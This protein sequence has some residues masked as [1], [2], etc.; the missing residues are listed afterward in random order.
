MRPQETASSPAFP[1]L[2]PIVLDVDMNSLYHDGDMEFLNNGDYQN[3]SN[4]SGR[5]LDELFPPSAES[6]N[7]N[8]I[9]SSASPAGFKGKK[10]QTQAPGSLKRPHTFALD[11]SSDSPGDNSSPGSSS[12]SPR[13]HGRNSSVGSAIHSESAINFDAD[14]WL[15]PQAFSDRQ[16]NLF[17]LDSMGGFDPNFADIE[18][19]NRV[20]DSA[21]DFESAAS[22][23]TPFSADGMSFS[24]ASKKKARASAAATNHYNQHK[25]PSMVSSSYR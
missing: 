6:R 20:M 23:P 1:H 13:D 9:E 22:S 14:G 21:F 3:P 2:D 7:G 4:D 24:G 25:A 16:E 19:S 17:G 18:S 15:N 12:D 11:S 8:G 5:D 10:Q